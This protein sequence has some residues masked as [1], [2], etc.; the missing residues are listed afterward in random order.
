[1][2]RVIAQC[3]SYCKQY[4][5]TLLIKHVP[6][7]KIIFGNYFYFNELSEINIITYNNEKNL[8]IKS[9]IHKKI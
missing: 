3:Y 5:R 2:L 6:S 8:L 9:K 1:M 4:N 7:Y